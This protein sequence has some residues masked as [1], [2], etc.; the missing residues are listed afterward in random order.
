MTCGVANEVESYVPT[1]FS[2]NSCLE[3]KEWAILGFD[4][5]FSPFSDGGDSG[6]LM[7]DAEGRMGGMLTG[8]SGFSA[9]ID[10]T[11]ATLMVALL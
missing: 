5:C 11:F 2:K 6:V 4:K 1:Y 3:S 8:S 10:V 7:V 9:K